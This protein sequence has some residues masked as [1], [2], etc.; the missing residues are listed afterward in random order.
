MAKIIS[1]TRL[2]AFLLIIFLL[3]P[4]CIF[5]SNILLLEL[6]KTNAWLDVFFTTIFQATLSAFF[7][8]V[9]GIFGAMGLCAF[10]QHKKRKFLE[11]TI[12]L[13]A[14]LPP[15][16]C[17]LAWVNVS[18]IF[19]R[20]PFS[21]ASVLVI[22]VLMNLGLVSVF[23]SRLFIIQAGGMS[24]WALIHGVSKWRFFNQVLFFELR[25][26]LLL[27][28]LLI[29]SLCFTSFSVPLLVGGVSGQTIEVFIAESLKDPATWPQAIA[30]FGIETIFLFIFFLSLYSQEKNQIFSSKKMEL[31]SSPLALMIP[32]LPTFLLLV[33]LF[34]P[35]FLSFEVRKDLLTVLPILFSATLHTLFLALGTGFGVL[36]LLFVTA[37]CCR[38]L[39]FR[40]FLISYASSPVAFM[41]F[42]FL[43]LDAD[44]LI[45]VWFK[46][47]MGLS[48]LFLPTL[49]RLFGESV[50]QRLKNQIL[51][52]DLM[53]ASWKMSFQKVIW[54]QCLPFFL[55]LSGIAAFWACGDFAYSSIVSSGEFHLALLIQD[56]FASHR[57]GLATA[58]IWLLLIIGILCFSFFAGWAFVLY[59]K[60]RP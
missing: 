29:F 10:S 34:D 49:Y 11:L 3:L 8:L 28:F 13:P 41:G 23:L 55:F 40:K 54:P 45:G 4:V 12:M 58:L 17:V 43:L 20:F 60:V 21:F 25:K 39:F 14:L 42:A 5:F 26:D 48:L 1:P 30:L 19:F 57:F 52:L 32:L 2:L 59:K 16:V 36:F 37:F 22:H 35:S 38:E 44:T 7:A 56:F 53:G 15:L 50:I 9:F 33:G 51:A 6:P 31:L 18:E 27:I 46:W 47:V 24:S